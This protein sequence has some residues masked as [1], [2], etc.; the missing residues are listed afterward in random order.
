MRSLIRAVLLLVAVPAVIA[1]QA[2]IPAR[3]VDW[4]AIQTEAVEVLRQYLRINSVNPP[5]N[6][7]ETARFLKAFLDKEGIEATILDTAELGAGRANLYARLKGNGRKRAIALVQ[8]MDVVPVTPAYWSMPPFSGDVKDGF[9]Y[10]RGALDMKGQ[11]VAHLMALVALKRSGVP[12]TRDI[13]FVA[14]AD[15]ELNSTGGIVFVEKHADLLKDVEYL[16]TEGGANVYRSGKLEYYSVG[17]AEKRTFW[18][19][20]TVKGT[21]SHGSRPT[22]ANPVPRLVAALDRIAKY[23]TPLHVT[24][25]VEK[26][27]HD[28]SR[29]YSGRR[30]AWLFD[31]K[32]ALANRQAREW[33][34]SDVYWNAILRNTISL[35]GLTGSNK[36]NVI[37]AEA[38]AELDV[39]LLPDQDPEVMLATLKR[40][41][42]DT[43]VHFQT[44]L[45]PKPPFE[46]PVNTD[47][48]RAVERAAKERDPNGFVT[49][50]MMTGATD[51][52]SYRRL[53]IIAYGLDPFRVESAD[54]QRGVHGNDER[55]SVENVG[56]GVRFL[57]DILR[58]AQ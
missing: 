39:R 37:P 12:L 21:P 6:E 35:T 24:P 25:G 31:V 33:I 20:L 41:V 48:F 36:T 9:V 26:F 13:V 40:I 2:A 32:K 46:S 5:G 22:R 29:N 45:Q 15:E 3:P 52:P 28:I 7:L 27:F 4:A 55:L 53:G 8:H 56:F 49:S 42:A 43:A 38:S 16:F 50:S 30:S 34:L 54:E 18:Q 11:G 14:N 58:Y 17:V 44:L 1:A 10:G 23:E 51:R 57:Y 47:L 19:K